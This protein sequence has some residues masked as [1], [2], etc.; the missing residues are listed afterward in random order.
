M[1]IEIELKAKIILI[2]TPN[3]SNDYS[4][5]LLSPIRFRIIS[6]VKL[7]PEY[8]GLGSF[9]ILLC[10]VVRF[11]EITFISFNNLLSIILYPSNLSLVTLLLVIYLV[12]V[13]LYSLRALTL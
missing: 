13:S 6:P 1:K 11:S 9:I 3:L 12:I 8:H 10:F 4:F 2:K 7:Y 5:V